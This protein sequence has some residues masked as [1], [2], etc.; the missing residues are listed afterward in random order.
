MQQLLNSKEFIESL[1]LLV[2]AALLTGILVPL[3]KLVFD[4]TNF[5]K[6]KLFEDQ[7][8]RQNNI[9][10]SQIKF[11]ETISTLL[12][13]FHALIAK[14]S[15]YQIH[16]PG[17]GNKNND[18]AKSAAE[19]YEE[20]FWELVIQNIQA[21]I[22]K[23]RR[24]VSPSVYEHLKVLYTDVIIKIDKEL[25]SLIENNASGEKWVNFHEDRLKG[26][27]VNEIDDTLHTLAEDMGLVKEN[28]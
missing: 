10:E 16:E 5:R 21:E 3:V 11:L 23:S 20:H 26:E 4:Y 13:K 27:L 28:Y 18:E 2:I 7:L 9:I 8:A 14:V 1:A 15:Y 6:Q 17:N 24:L 19:Q 22:S 25:V 12:W